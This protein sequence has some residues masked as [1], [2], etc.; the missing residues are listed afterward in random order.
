[1]IKVLLSLILIF[2]FSAA[3][4]DHVPSE[5]P[6]N[7][8]P[9]IDV[10]LKQLLANPFH[11][12][13]TSNPAYVI[14]AQLESPLALKNISKDTVFNYSTVEISLDSLTLN[15]VELLQKVIREGG[16]IHGNHLYN[17]EGV[18]WRIHVG[19]DHPRYW[20]RFD[21]QKF[22]RIF[23]TSDQT[24]ILFSIKRKNPFS[25]PELEVKQK[26]LSQRAAAALINRV[27]KSNMGIEPHPKKEGR[28]GTLHLKKPDAGESVCS[29]LF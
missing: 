29:K 14:K 4:A 6:G 22:N 27:T 7:K 21:G 25:A 3:F 16:F 1:M 5:N 13:Q 9:L 12:V 23:V 20:S 26:E 17:L 10:L 18:E 28:F 19:L 2:N 8:V 11:Y 15:D 24:G